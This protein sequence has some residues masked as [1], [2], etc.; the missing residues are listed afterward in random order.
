MTETTQEY[1]DQACMIGSDNAAW[2]PCPLDGGSS[3][4]A[5]RVIEEAMNLGTTD[6]YPKY[7]LPLPT[8]RGGKALYIDAVRVLLSSAD[9]NDYLNMIK[10]LGLKYNGVVRYYENQGDWKSQQKVEYDFSNQ[11]ASNVDQVAVTLHI[12]ATTGNDVRIR[13][14]LLKCYYG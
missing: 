12:V 6:F 9:T 10:V 13:G 5:F 4:S 8:N 7:T 2:V 3:F 1:V 11:N 14:V